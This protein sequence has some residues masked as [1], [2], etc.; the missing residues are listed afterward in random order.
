MSLLCFLTA[1]SPLL[2]WAAAGSRGD[3]IRVTS[4]GDHLATFVLHKPPP[5]QADLVDVLFH[6]GGI[7]FA[8]F[9]AL[10]ILGY[11]FLCL[12][13]ELHGNRK[14]ASPMSHLQEPASGKRHSIIFV[15]GT[16]EC[17]FQKFMRWVP[18]K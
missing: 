5:A 11:Y 15:G 6:S 13:V 1:S 12:V 3:G 7:L 9:T 2:L 18:L 4:L 16:N 8:S 14:P 10:L 17:D